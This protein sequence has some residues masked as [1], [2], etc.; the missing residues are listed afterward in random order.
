MLLTLLRPQVTRW[1]HKITMT[2]IVQETLHAIEDQ[3]C[4]NKKVPL[5]IVCEHGTLIEGTCSVRL[6]SSLGQRMFC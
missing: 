6:T 4:M 3:G 5:C 1:C 2:N